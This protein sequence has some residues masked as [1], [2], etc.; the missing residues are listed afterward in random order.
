M[1]YDE[2][3]IRVFKLKQEGKEYILSVSIIKDFVRLS[4]QENSKDEEG[5]FESDFSLKDLIA[6]HRFF[7]I[8]PNIS[9]AQYELIKAIEKQKV[10]VEKDLNVIRIAF[11]MGI[12]TD[13]I[14]IRL[15]LAKKDNVYK[16]LKPPEEQNP[17]TGTIKLKNR[18]EYPEDERRI[19]ALEGSTEKL[20]MS[21]ND[22]ITDVQGLL[23]ITQQLLK[24]AN[25]LSEENAK[26]GVRL[27]K[28]QKDNYENNLEVQIL[29]EEEQALN[30]E[31]IKLKSYIADLEKI[32]D[33]KKESLK[34]DFLESQQKNI[35]KD[36][37]DTGKGPKAVSSRYDEAFVKTFIPRITVKPVLDAYNEGILTSNRP[38]FYY[39]EKRLTQ[40]ITK[41][42]SSYDKLN[43]TDIN[44][45]EQNNHNY[46]Y[47]QHNSSFTAY[48]NNNFG[49]NYFNNNEQEG[50]PKDKGVKTKIIRPKVTKETVNYREISN[51]QNIQNKINVVNIGERQT[52]SESGVNYVR[53]SESHDEPKE[54]LHLNF[55]KS[56]IIKSLLE[57]QMLLA[58]INRY[59]RGVNFNLLYKATVDSDRAE[60]FHKKCDKAQRTLVLIETINQRR[61]GGYTTQSW[62]GD[63]VD[64]KDNEAFIFSLDKLQIY[65]IITDETAIGCYPEY[66]PVFLGCQI[67]INDNFFVK[68]GT[69]FRKNA[70]YATNSD[71]E[72][73][74]G[75]KF[76][77]IK[78]IEVFQVNLL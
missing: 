44:I 37:I 59:G 29:K 8:V 72:L 32:F 9:D 43:N 46:G 23:Q 64:K 65:N 53:E 35:Q 20:K 52:E 47:D 77:G 16:K 27:Q 40:Y 78:D 54:S 45:A 42:K 13:N 22:L 18:G 21:Q 51:N 61:F 30:E 41:N 50:S 38:P 2:R 19:R 36:E 15:S 10:G 56:D 24:D 31:N 70:H 26:L 60:V 67:K 58:K 6:I 5:F 57:E 25:L 75:V 7:L 34:K 11:Y 66:G 73:N 49:N 76:F 48:N 68:G 14:I 4:C 39:T 74:D 1:Q 3:D 69:T 55:I 28:V 62:E 63:C 33:Q 71:F 17:F 12:G